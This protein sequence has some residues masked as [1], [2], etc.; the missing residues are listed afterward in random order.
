MTKGESYTATL[1]RLDERILNFIS[2]NN[3]QHKEILEKITGN[4]KEITELCNHVNH[5]NGKVNERLNSLEDSELSR[6][7][8]WKTLIAVA[9]G[10]AAITSAVI[11][12]L[13]ALHVI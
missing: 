2:N 11:Q 12:I 3:E 10:S 6:K 4:K 7:T 1:A 5:Q 9:V 8:Q 13:G